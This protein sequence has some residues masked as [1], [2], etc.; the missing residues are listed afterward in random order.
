MHHISTGRCIFIKNTKY[1]ID[2]SDIA[3]LQQE[4]VHI[5]IYLRILSNSK[6]KEMGQKDL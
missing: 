4:G 5:A 2:S 3:G 6:V 1:P